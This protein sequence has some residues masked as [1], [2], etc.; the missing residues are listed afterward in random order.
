MHNY[1]RN[2]DLRSR[3]DKALGYMQLYCQNANN[4]RA[5]TMQLTVAGFEI[6]TP[7]RSAKFSF[8]DYQFIIRTEIKAT[9]GVAVLKT[10]RV[11]RLPDRIDE[12]RLEHIKEVDF[13]L[14]FNGYTG[15]ISAPEG[16]S[17]PLTNYQ[18]YFL[19]LTRVLTGRE[20]EE[21]KPLLATA[22]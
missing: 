22:N 12:W 15:F 5:D 14:T 16:Y 13:F 19:L 18:T 4:S 8:L 21:C 6:N 11:Y 2:F 20:A 17:N 7:E 3:V 10:Y 1:E 9:Q